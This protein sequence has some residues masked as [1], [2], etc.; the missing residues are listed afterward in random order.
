MQIGFASSNGSGL[1]A[2]YDCA[3][4]HEAKIPVRTSL[5]S[6][7]REHAWSSSKLQEP[8]IGQ[9]WRLKG[10]ECEWGAPRTPFLTARPAQPQRHSD[11][12]GTKV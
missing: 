8:K 6:S 5:K 9:R 12:I 3:S 1:E 11:L 2:G 4:G 7:P 10:G